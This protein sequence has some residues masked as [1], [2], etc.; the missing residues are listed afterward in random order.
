MVTAGNIPSRPPPGS[1][2]VGKG[3]LQVNQISMSVART[4]SSGFT[5]G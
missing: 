3:I 5:L 4:Y 1:T 2:T